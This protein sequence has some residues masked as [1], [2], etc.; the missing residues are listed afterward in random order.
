MQPVGSWGLL[1]GN[2]QMSRPDPVMI[3]CHISSD[4]S[5]A[6]SDTPVITFDRPVIGRMT[7]VPY[8]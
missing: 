1:R 4:R 2:T 3:D 5:G 6:M 7:A 8:V